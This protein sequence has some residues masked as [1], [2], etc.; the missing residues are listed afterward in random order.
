MT[1]G[2]LQHRIAAIQVDL[3]S[4]AQMIAALEQENSRLQEQSAV[5]TKLRES[6]ANTIA[7]Q[8]AME[9]VQQAGNDLRALHTVYS[10]FKLGLQDMFDDQGPEWL[11]ALEREFDK[12]TRAEAKRVPKLRL[13]NPGWAAHQVDTVAQLPDTR[14][15][16][17][18]MLFLAANP[19]DAPRL[20]LDEEIRA[21]KHS[22]REGDRQERFLVVEEWA[23][24]T[25]DLTGALM[26]HQPDL[27]H[28]S[29][30]GTEGGEFIL[31]DDSGRGRPVSASFMGQIFTAL[32]G[33]I[34][35]VV[36]NACYTER[37][38]HKIAETIECVVGTPATV[39]EKAARI[40]SAAFYQALGYGHPVQVA[41][42]LALA[43]IDG[44]D[45]AKED[46]PRLI[47][48]RSC[49]SQV[50]FS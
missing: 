47:D 6:L 10:D 11:A 48:P 19:S 20:D 34:R 4:L 25:S 39:G 30:H 12:A 8:F 29:G 5:L 2:D 31:K 42:D 13:W 40:F 32:H 41:F 33:N 17:V 7:Q 45:I 9:I 43:A 50:V 3:H 36:L 22:L 27:V 15:S 28:F 14:R 16:S 24:R 38:A 1:S 37:Q 26:H 18:K 35:C 44:E 49:C 23:V 46:R 21:I